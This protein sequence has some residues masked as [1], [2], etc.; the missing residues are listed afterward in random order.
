MQLKQAKECEEYVDRL[1]QWKEVQKHLNDLKDHHPDSYQHSMRVGMLALDIGLELGRDDDDLELLALGGM[2]HDLGKCDT[3]EEILNKPSRLSP[4]ELA[5]IRR[6]PRDGFNRLSDPGFAEVRK[7]VVAH[8]EHQSNPYPR[9]PHK[10]PP[11]GTTRRTPDPRITD[12]TMIVAIAD[13]FDALNS[14]RAYKER[15]PL[16]DI[17]SLLRGQ[18]TGKQQYVSMAL[19]RY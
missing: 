10:P 14:V 9:D 2:L 16:K 8:H 7:I 13:M 19:A 12:L 18:F 6:H 15:L 4:R 1:A 5:K 17:A 11:A 3:A